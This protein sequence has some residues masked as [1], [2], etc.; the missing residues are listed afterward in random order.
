MK[1]SWK[2]F[3]IVCAV[4]A[5]LGIL[6][7]AAGV[8]LGGLSL[9]NSVEDTGLFGR[10]LGQAIGRGAAKDDGYV[11][12]GPDGDM[13]ISYDEIS[14]ISL[15]VGGFGV[16]IL[17]YD[18]EHVRTDISEIRPDLRDSVRISQDGSELEIE[19]KNNRWNTNGSGTLYISV[20]RGSYYDS[21]FADVGAGYLEIR[22]ISAA[23]LSLEVGAGQI[24]AEDITAETAE[25]RCGAG[26]IIFSGEVLKE[27]GI[28]CDLG[29]IS[30]T[31]SGTADSYD[32]EL[33]C[34]MGE[35]VLGGE[36][37]GGL[38]NEVSIDNESSRLI[39]ADCDMGKIEIMFE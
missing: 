8:A 10:W 34:S 14:D 21:V 17:P 12:G 16:C 15:D 23:D 5:S 28:E 25:I 29:E 11:P 32:Y 2:V 3:W 39:S 18:G 26:Q 4:L 35:I 6:L 27:A 37:Y 38:T 36:S 22:E 31:A 9:L 30:Y 20:P 1:K 24:I 19:M 33:A 7:A 13:I